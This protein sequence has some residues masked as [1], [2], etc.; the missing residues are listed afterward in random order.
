[1]FQRQPVVERRS[2]HLGL[3]ERAFQLRPRQ[4][5]AFIPRQRLADALVQGLRAALD[6][7]INDDDIPDRDRVYIALASNRIAN[8]YN[9]WGL[10]AGEWRAQGQ[11]MD[12]L[13]SNLSR[14][15][16]LNEQFEM[17]D[18]LPS[19]SFTY[20]ALPSVPV[21]KENT[22][23][24]IKLR[25]VSKNSNDVCYASR[26]TTTPYAV[27]EPS[28]WL[29]GSINTETILVSV[30]NGPDGTDLLGIF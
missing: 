15:L 7:L 3:R 14:M 9:A 21:T 25:R 24:V 29:K 17:D 22:Y 18:S 19:R 16:N 5:G 8:A 26:R 20:V 6:D 4:I 12:A 30:D 28:L 11:S 1:M 23:R 13:L 10:R 2:V 27:L